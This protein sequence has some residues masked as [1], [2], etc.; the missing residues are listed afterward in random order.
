[1]SQKPGMTPQEIERLTGFKINPD[2]TITNP[3][4]QPEEEHV[5]TS[6]KPREWAKTAAVAAFV[7]RLASS[8]ISG[9]LANAPGLGTAGGAAV[10]GIGEGIAQWIESPDPID[11]S[12]VALESGLGAIPFG[13]WVS[14]GRKAWNAL[15]G[16]GIIQAGNMAR[17]YNQEGEFLPDTPGE[18]LF[19]AA[20]AGAGGVAGALSTPLINQQIDK[21]PVPLGT[22]VRATADGIAD[23]DN[24]VVPTYPPSVIRELE[25]AAEAVPPTPIDPRKGRLVKNKGNN[26]EAT[27]EAK[28]ATSGLR[29]GGVKRTVEADELYKKDNELDLPGGDPLRKTHELDPNIQDSQKLQDRIAKIELA[30]QRE[31]DK[32]DQSL[33]QTDPKTQAIADRLAKRRDIDI[34]NARIE[35]NRRLGPAVSKA[36]KAEEAA[37][38]A[39][40][41]RRTGTDIAEQKIAA[42]KAQEQAAKDLQ[43]V[44]KSQD[45]A[46]KLLAAEKEAE[47]AARAVEEAK[48][49]L[50]PSDPIVTE[51]AKAKIPGGSETARRVWTKPKEEDPDI[52][53]LLDAEGGTPP[54]VPKTP[55]KKVDPAQAKHTNFA[56]EKEALENLGK[57][58][59]SGEVKRV[60]RGKWRIVYDEPDAPTVAPKAPAPDTPP[61]APAG[62][63]LRTPD[64]SVPPAPESPKV[65]VPTAK[66]EV[67]Q[68]PKVSDDDVRAELQKF[69]SQELDRARQTYKDQMRELV[70]EEIAR[71][72]N[73][74][75]DPP[76]TAPVPAKPRGPKPKGGAPAKTAAPESGNTVQPKAAAPIAPKGTPKAEARQATVPNAQAAAQI[77]KTAASVSKQAEAAKANVTKPADTGGPKLG[78]EVPKASD[79]KLKPRDLAEKDTSGMTADELKAYY[80][81]R[82]AYDD[83]KFLA[84]ELA[85]RKPELAKQAEGVATRFAAGELTD[86]AA[87]QEVSRLRQAF[88]EAGERIDKDS[89]KQT[90]RE[91]RVTE[92]IRDPATDHNASNVRRFESAEEALQDVAESAKGTPSGR[93]NRKVL[94]LSENAPKAAAPIAAKPAPKAD[95]AKVGRSKVQETPKAPA[96][97]PK[98]QFKKPE[99][100]KGTDPERTAAQAATAPKELRD[101]ARK[102]QEAWDKYWDL[103]EKHANGQA[104]Y[105]ETRAAGKA[106]G[107]LKKQLL[108]KAEELG[109]DSGLARPQANLTKVKPPKGKPGRPKKVQELPPNEQP[110]AIENTVDRLK[111]LN[112]KGELKAEAFAQLGLATV[113]ALTGAA[114]TPDAPWM[115]LAIGGLAGA[116]APSAFKA[117]SR[118]IDKLEGKAKTQSVKALN[119]W[120]KD[121]VET[122]LAVAPEVYRANLLLHPRN[123]VANAFVGPYGTTMMQGIEL[124]LSGDPAGMRIIKTLLSPE[125]GRKFR[126]LWDEA[127]EHIAT[128]N[129]RAEIKGNMGP[130]ALRKY[131][132]FPAQ[133]MTAGDEAARNIM[134]AAGL[135]EELARKVTLTSEPISG[136]G[137]AIGNARKSKSGLADK[138]SFA[139]Q[140]IIPFYRTN[141]NQIEQGLMRVPYLGSK[142][143]RYWKETP[144]PLKQEIMQQVVVTPAAIAAGYALGA[145]TPKKHQNMTIKFVSNFT[146][147]YGMLA[148][149]GF[150]AGVAKQN[151]EDTWGDRAIAAARQLMRRDSPLPNGDIVLDVI[152]ALDNVQKGD[153]SNIQ[154]PYGVLPPVLSSKEKI[155]I[156]TLIREPSVIGKSGSDLVESGA[157]LLSGDI[158][159]SYEKALDSMNPDVQVTEK[160]WFIDTKLK[161]EPKEKS[162][163]QRNLE[164][165][166]K[167]LIGKE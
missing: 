105:E 81:S 99:T 13:K 72:K 137:K 139:M 69:T 36:T 46:Q 5:S 93:P 85:E 130:E 109:L 120:T 131:V 92:Y 63:A 83:A 53:K 74:P 124:A 158:K 140:M 141:V 82:S 113:G 135:S 97:S 47:D 59:R 127:G 165:Q 8:F 73:P 123:L 138:K 118:Q 7:P 157:K 91:G 76:P 49:G 44:A 90:V 26:S 43:T 153:F 21:T 145:M 95:P 37:D 52:D 50:V 107:E 56:T 68:T 11:Q 111:K 32:L 55:K 77:N 115:G 163:F 15:R 161:K 87:K 119:D 103:K 133:F 156:P 112:Q 30:Y 9:I 3:Y 1:M 129:E 27:L 98:G 100:V 150:L 136:W 33:L 155:S 66:P 54:P 116:Y 122:F 51:T 125:F 152:D 18:L 20:T 23:P 60:G 114:Q 147:Q 45:E 31:L 10:S 48:A 110:K 94:T 57:S 132:T 2:G 167:K 14:G 71:R 6:R 28:P 108:D 39:D 19:D 96:E 16:A 25:K 142:L 80:K 164:R 29:V 35:E 151:G 4:A 75:T 17:R 65:E 38:L 61:P 106:A 41:K 64:G 34:R 12:T 62:D 42:T 89:Y 84:K 148:S 162:A 88:R 67:P 102:E 104:T 22:S 117:F 149:F 160:E 146:G 121:K 166:R 40:T 24:W 78:N 79:K 154:L 70:D 143:R 101:L 134:M 128:S 144:I 58:G 126:E 86:K 159:G